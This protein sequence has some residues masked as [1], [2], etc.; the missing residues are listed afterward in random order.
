MRLPDLLPRTRPL[1]VDE[2][3]LICQDH[4]GQNRWLR[5]WCHVWERNPIMGRKLRYLYIFQADPLKQGTNEAPRKT[6]PKEHLLPEQGSCSTAACSQS[7]NVPSQR[8][9]RRSAVESSWKR[10]SF[11]FWMCGSSS[12]SMR[13]LRSGFPVAGFAERRLVDYIWISVEVCELA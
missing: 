11:W 8:P 2:S 7:K 4:W 3:G 5:V 12:L 13:D 9:K 1:H 6:N 10:L